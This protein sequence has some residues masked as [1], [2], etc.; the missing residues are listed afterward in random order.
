MVVSMP[1]EIKDEEHAI[2]LGEVA[3]ECRVKKLE[4]DKVAKV[5]FRTKKYLFT[6]KVPLEKLD[7]FLSKL[8]CK[9]IEV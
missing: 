1:I 4:K 3:I 8:K 2:K 6:Y 9:V 5:K 7:E